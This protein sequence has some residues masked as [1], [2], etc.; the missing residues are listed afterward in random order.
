[1]EAIFDPFALFSK[2]VPEITEGLFISSNSSEVDMKEEVIF[3]NFWV[4]EIPL[5]FENSALIYFYFKVN[6][7]QEE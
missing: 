7:L 3:M 6:M 1:M 4:P 2:E 5:I